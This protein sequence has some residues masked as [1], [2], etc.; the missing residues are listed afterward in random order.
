[1]ITTTLPVLETE[2]DEAAKK[3][4]KKPREIKVKID[5]SLFAEERWEKNF[6]AQ[7]KTETLFNYVERVQE[8]GLAST[9]TAT[10]LSNLKALYCFMEGDEIADFK[11]FLQLFNLADTNHLQK[12]VD[13]IKFVFEIALQSAVDGKN[14]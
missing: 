6:P 3:L 12:L 8:K 7:A 5:T 1:M 10:V 13:K 11:S 9:D 2:L 4:I 14:S